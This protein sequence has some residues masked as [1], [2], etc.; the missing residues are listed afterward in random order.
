MVVGGKNTKEEATTTP[1]EPKKEIKQKQPKQDVQVQPEKKEQPKQDIQTQPEKKEQPKQNVQQSASGFTNPIKNIDKTAAMNAVKEKA[2]KDFP[3]DYMTQ[4]YLADEQSKA[5]D[6]L[7]GIELKSQEE[8][9][10]MK[11]VIND[12][13][14]NFMPT[15]YVYEEQIKAMNKQ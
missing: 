11:K 10:V 8:V 14:N 6:Y 1:T 7:N 4:N 3:D 9:N 15:K 12:F 2:K 5:F 13:P